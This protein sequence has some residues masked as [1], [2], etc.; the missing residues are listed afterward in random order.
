MIG[1]DPFRLFCIQ[2]ACTLVYRPA[3]AASAA[4]FT[5]PLF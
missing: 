2:A 5:S 1:D 3:S 4:A